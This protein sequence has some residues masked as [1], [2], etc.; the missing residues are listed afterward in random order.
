[1]GPGGEG[2]DGLDGMGFWGEAKR[3]NVTGR[4]RRKMA[5]NWFWG[6]GKKGRRNHGGRRRKLIG[7]KDENGKKG[8]I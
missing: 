6:M 1:M 7:E 4:K 3:Q 2:G 5:Q 8:G